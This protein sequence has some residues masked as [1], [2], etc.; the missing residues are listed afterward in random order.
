MYVYV[1]HLLTVILDPN[2]LGG[3]LVESRIFVLKH[4]MNTDCRLHVEFWKFFL[5]SKDSGA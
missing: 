1:K 5:I 3:I 4:H 2:F